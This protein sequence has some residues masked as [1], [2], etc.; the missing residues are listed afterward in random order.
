[1][2]ILQWERRFSVR[3]EAMD[4]DHRELF[5]VLNDLWQVVERSSTLDAIAETLARVTLAMAAHFSREEAMLAQWNYPRCRTHMEEHQQFISRLDALATAAAR[6]DPA[7]I[8]ADAIDFIGEWLCTHILK[9][10]FDYA[11]F[12]SA[13]VGEAT[14]SAL[15]RNRIRGGMRRS[16]LVGVVLAVIVVAVNL[17]M[18]GLLIYALGEARAAREKE[19]RS[20]VENGA[21]LLD[22]NITEWAG[23]VDLSLNVIADQL[24][25][26]IRANGGLEREKVEEILDNHHSWLSNL[27]NFRVTDSAGIVRFGPGVESGKD[28]SFADRAYFIAQ[29]KN[30]ALGMFVSDP[31]VGRVAKDWLVSFSR[32]YVNPD[33]TFA[34]I[35]S[36]TVPIS[37]F[38]ELLSR[39]DL[40]PKGIALLRDTE[41][42]LVSRHPS[43]P[44]QKIGSKSFSK[45]LAESIASGE[46]ARTFRAERTADGIERIDAYRRLAAV[47]YHLVVGV[48]V[49]EWLSQWQTDVR[50]AI[51]GALIFFA[52]SS[53]AGWGLWRAFIFSKRADSA[54][55]LAREIA[56]TKQQL[57]EAHRI[58]RLGFVEVNCA[59]DIWSLGEGVQEM[60]GIASDL[61]SGTA[62]EVLEKVVPADRTRLMELASMARGGGFDLEIHV[63][64]RVLHAMGE[65][66]DDD[67]S[68]PSV[69]ITLQDI[70]QR[71]AAEDE[72]AKMIGRMS[73]ASRLE[74][75]GTL[76]G[77]VAHEINTPAQYIGDNL[78]FIRD[79]LQRLLDVVKACREATTSGEWGPVAERVATIRYDFA[80]RELPAAADQALDGISRISAIVQAIKAFSYPSGN[81]PQPFDL[82]RAIEIAATVTRSQWKHVAE[83]NLDLAP[84]LPQLNAVEGEINQVLVN[85]IV[86]AAQAIG[87]KGASE[88]GRIDVQTRAFDGM[89][90]F[91]VTDSGVGIPE[92]NLDRLFEL[93]FTTKPPGQGTGQGLAITHAII[94]R[95]QGT[96]MVESE[97]GAGACFRIRLPVAVT[98]VEVAI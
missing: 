30:P 57:S 37:Q 62:A 86:N 32:R 81:D 44:S 28:V 87:E 39:I 88:M 55:K 41:G 13:P 89:I 3:I 5:S 21:Q 82:N 43:N 66:T 97:P 10:D 56:R 83:L 60:L 11:R 15:G 90:E 78:S 50:K 34:G 19:A 70:T 22:Q 46:K 29:R 6:G 48:S 20:I 75:L 42:G 35:I 69:V 64:D 95:H 76:A 92:E 54:T 84:E 72:R 52:L 40:G 14:P 65:P 93:F 63:E 47:P 91:S 4:A 51:I 31:I 7:A 16:T 74:S 61:A 67:A 96:V 18:A 98:P 17:F 25:S 80:A 77:G 1:M 33:G 38:D 79:W 94:H 12:K 8:N 23:K 59:T 9:S 45:E 71:R 68:A 49:E 73:E 53:G 27:A 36:A 85:L 26:A 24:S 58:A 2:P